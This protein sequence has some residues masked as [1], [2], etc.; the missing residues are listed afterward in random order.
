MLAHACRI[1]QKQLHLYKES[2]S[3]KSCRWFAHPLL[4]VNIYIPSVHTPG[5]VRERFDA[6]IYSSLAYCIASTINYAG[7]VGTVTLVLRSVIGN[8]VEASLSMVH[9][10]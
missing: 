3:T 9:V 7:V 2:G 8:Y 1:V 10:Y 4:P 6:P 5:S